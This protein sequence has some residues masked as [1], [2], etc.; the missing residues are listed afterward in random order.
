MEP[1]RPGCK[2]CA[3]RLSLRRARAE[4]L[5]NWTTRAKWDSNLR[6]SDQED[7]RAMGGGYRR[8]SGTF[9]GG[10]GGAR[11][12]EIRSHCGHWIGLSFP[13]ARRH[14]SIGVGQRQCSP[15]FII[16]WAL[17]ISA[18]VVRCQRAA[19]CGDETSDD[20]FSTAASPLSYIE[21]W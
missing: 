2:G 19:T 11:I 14:A 6:W 16:S 18:F 15:P 4:V 1:K 3:R 10:R 13:M 9:D 17:L 5:R 8:C 20:S 21:S 12:A 7:G